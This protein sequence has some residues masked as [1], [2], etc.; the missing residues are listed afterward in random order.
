MKN[1]T[2]TI[3]CSK[4]GQNIVMAAKDA[5]IRW[6]FNG[7]F[8]RLKVTVK[9]THCNQMSTVRETPEAKELLAERIKKKDYNGGGCDIYSKP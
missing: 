9:C 5:N 1:T 3:G 6:R 4:C 7:G 8:P 2:I